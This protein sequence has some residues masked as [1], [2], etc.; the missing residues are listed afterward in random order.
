MEVKLLGRIK[1]V[2]PRCFV[3]IFATIQ[4]AGLK[5]GLTS[6]NKY[7][8]YSSVTSIHFIE[9]V[10]ICLLHVDPKNSYK[11]HSI[12]EMDKITKV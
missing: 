12:L 4:E 5:S 6:N 10:F 7:Q 11:L 2:A 9:C 8:H 3:R 1:E